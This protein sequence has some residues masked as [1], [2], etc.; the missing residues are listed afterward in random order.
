MYRNFI[1]LIVLLLLLSL[2]ACGSAHSVDQ[3]YNK[4]KDDDQVTALRIPSVVIDMLSDLSP[5]MKSL[6]GD[7]DDIR[8]MK[9][10]GMSPAKFNSLNTQI[11][12]LTSS[13]F[14][15]VYRKN[16]EAKRNV[17]SIR[18]KRNVVKEILF[19]KTDSF[20]TTLLYLNGNFEPSKVR[21]L[22]ES[23]QFN[24]V[25]ETLNLQY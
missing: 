8:L 12:N 1:W 25:S 14:I 11:N 16:E 7:T 23:D 21:N 15:E 4:H 10:S 6:F 18:E 20:N 22:A 3:F 5:E 24:K 9:F 19:Y 13:S 2:N 17:I